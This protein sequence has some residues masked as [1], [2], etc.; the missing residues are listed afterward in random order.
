MDRD[1]AAAVLEAFP[2]KSRFPVLVL[3]HFPAFPGDFPGREDNSLA[4]AREH[5]V[6]TIFQV[7]GLCPDLVHRNKHRSQTAYIHK[8]IISKKSDISG[9]SFSY[10]GH[11]GDSVDSAQRMI[12]HHGAG[13][14]RQVLHSP[15]LDIDIKVIKTS[16]AEFHSLVTLLEKT[17]DEI[18]MYESLKSGDEEFREPSEFFLYN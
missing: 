2:E 11:Q 6:H 5:R 16:P 9:I 8:E 1:N 12:A 7:R 18:L 3:N 10:N 13:A 15:Y 14:V 17:V 4:A